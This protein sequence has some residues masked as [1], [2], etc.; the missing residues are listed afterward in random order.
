MTGDKVL[1][2][3][4]SKE[5]KG[6]GLTAGLTNYS[7]HY[8]TGL[9]IARRL[10]KQVGLADE[11]KPTDKVDGEMFLVE[12]E[13]DKRPLKALLDVGIQRTTTGARIFGALKGA[14]D[15][16]VNVPHTVKRFPGYTRASVEVV[17]NKRGK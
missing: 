6:M 7:A 10:L 11:Y 14:C 12:C 15:G 17:T 4:D 16:G 9:L 3:A 2:T 13:G 5:L 1:C 8:A